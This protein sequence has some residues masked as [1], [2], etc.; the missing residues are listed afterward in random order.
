[1]VAQR[2]EKRKG[3]TALTM[4][5]TKE[6]QNQYCL[7]LMISEFQA[8]LKLW[9]KRKKLLTVR[10]EIHN[11]VQPRMCAWGKPHL[12]TASFFAQK[13]HATSSASPL[14]LGGSGSEC[15]SAAER[16]FPQPFNTCMMS[17]TREK[18]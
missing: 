7:T 8:A 11:T 2:I 1:M 12:A 3:M 15:R 10:D 16:S 9:A 18:V 4:V 14:S 17:E 13:G 6:L 5:Y